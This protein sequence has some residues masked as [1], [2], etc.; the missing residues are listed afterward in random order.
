MLV[1]RT[2]LL[3][4]FGYAGVILIT[5]PKVSVFTLGLETTSEQ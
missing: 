3:T 4:K 1:W 2:K 5:N